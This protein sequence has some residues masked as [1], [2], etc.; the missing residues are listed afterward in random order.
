MMISLK[1]VIIHCCHREYPYILYRIIYN[2][3]IYLISYYN[4]YVIFNSLDLYITTGTL[5]DN[6]NKLCFS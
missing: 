3:F 5:V 6:S 2:E 4:N 1:K